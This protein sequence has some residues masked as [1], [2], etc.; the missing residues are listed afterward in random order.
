MK[1][2]VFLLCILFSGCGKNRSSTKTSIDNIKS[3]E[4]S[5][6]KKTIVTIPDGAVYGNFKTTTAS[7][8]AYIAAVDKTSTTISFE[9]KT[10]PSLVIPE[11]LGGS[12]ST[13]QFNGFNADVLLLTGKIKDPQF[14]KYFVYQFTNGN[15]REVVKPFAI[16]ERHKDQVITPI[17]IDTTNTK[18]VIRYYSVFDLDETSS[19]GYTWKL[20]TESIPYN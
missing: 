4:T 10:L 14:I 8:Y 7:V 11:A 6:S 2:I 5:R 13:L 12:L 1:L 3:I 9:N 18:H 19:E 17:Q 20:L 16:H 15:W